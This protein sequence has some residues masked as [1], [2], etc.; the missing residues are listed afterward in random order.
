MPSVMTGLMAVCVFVGAVCA[1]D[2]PPNDGFVTDTA[3]ML[4]TDQKLALDTMLGDYQMKTS[5]EIAVITVASLGGEEISDVAVQIG[6]AWG[7]GGELK[8]NGILLLVSRDD[9][10]LFIATGY[11]LEGAVPDIV[12]KGVIEEDIVPQFKE[13]AYFEGIQA[14]IGS[15]QKHIAGEYTAD[16]YTKSST[17]GVGF[18]GFI[19]FAGVILLQIL[20][21]FLGRT[22]SW[23]LGGV[24]GAVAGIVLTVLFA[25]WLSIPLLTVIG[26][27]VDYIASKNPGKIGKG[28]RGGWG[29]WSGG[30]WGSGGGGSSGGGFG[31]FGGGSFGGGGAGGKW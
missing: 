26:L 27:L 7:V 3:G 30:G 29:G 28:G 21:S 24:L 15:L 14:G 13:G 5:N 18:V 4:T 10:Q 11:G 1:F 6:R 17:S 22:K 9:R 31:G 16:R 20:L 25:W 12:A 8:D 19:F 2:V 23:W